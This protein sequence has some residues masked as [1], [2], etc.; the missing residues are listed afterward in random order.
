MRHLSCPC[1]GEAR[2]FNAWRALLEQLLCARVVRLVAARRRGRRLRFAQADLAKVSS[3]LGRSSVHD[4]N[5]A[6]S[7]KL[8]NV[9]VRGL[10]SKLGLSPPVIDKLV[11]PTSTQQLLSQESSAKRGNSAHARKASLL[12]HGA[13]MVGVKSLS[14]IDG[15]ACAC[16]VGTISSSLCSRYRFCHLSSLSPYASLQPFQCVSV[17]TSAYACLRRGVPLRMCVCTEEIVR[18]SLCACLFLR[19]S[20]CVACLISAPVPAP[21]PALAPAPVP[22][23]LLVPAPLPEPEPERA[24]VGVGVWGY[25]NGVVGVGVGVCV[26]VCVCACGCLCVR[27]LAHVSVFVRVRAFST[28]MILFTPF[29]S[30][31][32]RARAAP[33]RPH[34]SPPPGH[35]ALQAKAAI[36]RD[37]TARQDPT[38]SCRHLKKPALST[39]PRHAIN[40]LIIVYVVA[41][42]QVSL[43]SHGTLKLSGPSLC[44]IASERAPSR[45]ICIRTRATYTYCTRGSERRA[46]PAPLRQPGKTIH[47]P[48][49]HGAAGCASVARSPHQ[50]R[51]K[52]ACAYWLR[53]IRTLVRVVLSAII[54]LATPSKCLHASVAIA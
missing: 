49:L 38:M 4:A 35:C 28:H 39:E 41:A 21:A 53:R 8:Q 34:A 17:C 47:C 20:Q 40:I 18:L 16:L 54:S 7:C 32:V 30:V 31:Y 46:A 5:G 26:C 11:L 1:D 44:R 25:G 37:K 13:F 45:A 6:C 2:R 43:N 19:P 50:A 14:L 36:A 42:T 23:P 15:I 3:Q 24:R 9:P 52:S 29:F 33:G 22:A 12:K 27:A 48:H 10:A 51:R